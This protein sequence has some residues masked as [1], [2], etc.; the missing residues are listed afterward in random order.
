MWWTM[1][2]GPAREKAKADAELGDLKV[3]ATHRGNVVEFH[4]G[5]RSFL[6]GNN[7]WLQP[8][9]NDLEKRVA[10]LAA[11]AG[12]RTRPDHIKVREIEGHLALFHVKRRRYELLEAETPS[13]YR[14][15]LAKLLWPRPTKT[16]LA[17]LREE[18][19]EKQTN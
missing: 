9:G 14:R 11:R 1:A 18:E 4:N 2:S 10:M 7:G 5:R 6:Q 19:N 15:A 13:A 3:V 17:K 16:R 12:M 8:F